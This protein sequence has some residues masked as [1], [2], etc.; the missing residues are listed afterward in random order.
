MECNK[1]GD[2]MKHRDYV[3]RI[4][5]TKGGKSKKSTNTEDDLRKL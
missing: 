4:V 2:K 1:C 3:K 5:K